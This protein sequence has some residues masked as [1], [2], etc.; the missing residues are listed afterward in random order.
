M[1]FWTG[2]PTSDTAVPFDAQSS[3][4]SEYIPVGIESD[5]SPPSPVRH[6]SEFDDTVCVLEAPGLTLHNGRGHQIGY[7]PYSEPEV[8][9]TVLMRLSPSPQLSPT[10]PDLTGVSLVGN[11]LSGSKPSHKKLFGE[12]GWLGSNADLRELAGDNHKSFGLRRLGK[13]FKMHVEDLVEDLVSRP[14]RS[15]GRPCPDISFEQTGDLFKVN[16]GIHSSGPIPERYG[17][18]RTVPV[19]LD[20]PTQARL[21]SQLEVMICV[22]ANRFLVEQH[23][24]GLLSGESISKVTNY[25]A[26]KNRPRV[27]EF[28]YDQATQRQLIL[29]NLRTVQFNGC[30]ATNPVQLRTNLNN[31]KAIGKEMSVRTFCA[32]DSAIRKQMYDIHK[33]LEMLG[34]PCSGRNGPTLALTG[35]IYVFCLSFPRKYY[36]LHVS[37]R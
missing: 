26:A 8:S 25:W 10:A 18:A 4:S 23:N 31:W 6:Q 11:P 3:A 14:P 33:L 37:L 36:C 34:A 1:K 30:S 22:V 9:Q 21:Y 13:K 15:D 17:P 35:S 29:S 7:H 16:L 12:N 19:S 2:S 24:R 20:A 5:L 28:H 32:P 27:V